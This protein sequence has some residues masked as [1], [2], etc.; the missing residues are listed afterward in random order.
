MSEAFRQYLNN[1]S[2]L[3]EAGIQTIASLAATA[4]VKKR[5][6]LLRAGEVCRH[7]SFITKGCMK[8]YRLADDG[9]EHII[10]FA[11][12]GWWVSDRESLLS[13]RPA[14]SY[15]AALED[16]EV[17]QWTNPQFEDLFHTLPAF[18]ALFKR[19]VSRALDASQN[20]IYATISGTADERYRQF[21]KRYPGLIGRVPLHLIASYLGLTRETL[22]RIRQAA[23]SEKM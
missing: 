8:L 17:L 1:N 5:Q 14:E 4:I 23:R 3:S 7:H 6:Y 20:R 10:K 2:G 21:L 13:G 16:T 19:L 22:T 18:D 15:I 11:V 12:E 9:T